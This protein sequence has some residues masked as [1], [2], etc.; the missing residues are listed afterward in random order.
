[1]RRNSTFAIIYII[2]GII[3]ASNRGYLIDLG[4]LANLFSAILAILL[5]PLLL[6]GVNLHVAF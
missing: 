3:L 6:L 5:W 2:I 1:M 4:S